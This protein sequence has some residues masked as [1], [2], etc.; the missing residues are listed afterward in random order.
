MVPESSHST[1]AISGIPLEIIDLSVEVSRSTFGPPSTNVPVT[2]EEFHRGPGFWQVTSVCQS[3]H[4]G[5][6]ID[7]PLHCLPEGKTTDD[8]ALADVSGEIRFFDI[9]KA[10]GEG[11]S[12]ADLE[13]TDSGLSPGEIAVLATG[14]TDRSWGRFPQFFTESPY[15]EL[16]AAK[17]LVERRPKAVVFDFF[18]EYA[19][20]KPQFTSEEFVV[21]RELLG[22]GIYLIEQATNLASLKGRA[23][24][25]FAAFY[26][27]KGMEGAPA[28]LFALSSAVSGQDGRTI[29]H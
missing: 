29:Q 22:A 5:T 4:T 19:A 8:V 12:R 17:W 24:L 7:T 28:R 16:D 1:F 2:F 9:P 15:L 3:L 25:L 27:V 21:H 6:H 14:W 10:A 26:K 11:V 18:E 20:R 13:A 23:A